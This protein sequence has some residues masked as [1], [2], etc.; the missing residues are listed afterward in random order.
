VVVNIAYIFSLTSEI[1]HVVVWI[2]NM[3]DP[4]SQL[5]KFNPLVAIYLSPAFLTLQKPF[6]AEA[7]F[8]LSCLGPLHKSGFIFTINCI[9]L[10]SPCEA[11]DFLDL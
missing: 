5:L 8:N 4:L 2:R 1:F 6:M 7:E 11:L 10:C 3:N 9:L